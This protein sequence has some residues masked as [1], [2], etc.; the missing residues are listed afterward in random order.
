MSD[1]LCCKPYRKDGIGFLRF[2][3]Q[4]GVKTSTV[5]YLSKLRM[6]LLLIFGRVDFREPL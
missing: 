5:P 4:A 6:T 2:S 1:C 3:R